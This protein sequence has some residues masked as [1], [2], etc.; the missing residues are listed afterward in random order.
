VSSSAQ[1]AGLPEGQEHMA[2]I[3]GTK[4]GRRLRNPH[5]RGLDRPRRLGLHLASGST[6]ILGAIAAWAAAGHTDIGGLLLL[7]LTAALVR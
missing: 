6:V 5:P 3:A 7:A 1:P 4:V 2:L